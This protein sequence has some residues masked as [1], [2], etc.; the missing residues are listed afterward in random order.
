MRLTTYT[1]Y[2]LRVLMHVALQ[3]GELVR[4]DDIATG[5]RIS[6]NHLTKVVHKLG[7]LGLLSTV[8]GRNGGMCLA[9]PADNISVGEVVREFEPDFRLVECFDAQDSNCR[10]EPACALKAAFGDALQL[11]LGHLD[12]V[13]VA[14]LVQP[15]KKLAALLALP[16]RVI[17]ARV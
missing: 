4:V 1:D 15:G 10:I 17:S 14:D 12:E 9:R 2:A 7:K 13:T 5:Y 3:Q 11:F 8:Q 6:R 16:V